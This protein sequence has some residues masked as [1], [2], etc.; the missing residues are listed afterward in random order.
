MRGAAAWK[1]PMTYAGRRFEHWSWD[2]SLEVRGGEMEEGKKKKKNKSSKDR[3]WS[4]VPDA[5][6]GVIS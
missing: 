1:E 6:L 3:T 4:A 2:L 5:L